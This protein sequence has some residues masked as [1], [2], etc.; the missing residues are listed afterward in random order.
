[1]LESS[2]LGTGGGAV[3]TVLG[4]R[5]TYRPSR[6]CLPPAGTVLQITQKTEV[7]RPTKAWEKEG[8]NLGREV[9]AHRPLLLGEKDLDCSQVPSPFL[10]GLLPPTPR[11]GRLRS[12]CCFRP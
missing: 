10:H 9:P 12:L 7:P 6:G 1:M 8:P 11:L 5:T 2:L 4:E 3:F